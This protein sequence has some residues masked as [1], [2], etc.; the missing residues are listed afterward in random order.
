MNAGEFRDPIEVLELAATVGGAYA[1]KTRSRAWAKVEPQNGSN[2]FSRNGISARSV[3]LTIRENPALTAHNALRWDGKHLFISDIDRSSR[4]YYVLMCALIEPVT[5]TVKRTKTEIAGPLNRPQT[6]D[7]PPLVFPAC[8]TE[9]Y[10]GQ[11]QKEPM[12]Y[13]ETRFVLV[14]PKV[15]TIDAG[16]LVEISGEPYEVLIPRLLD[17]YKNEYEILRKADN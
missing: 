2:I 17:E 16:E 3:K 13:S 7:L 9:K 8:L 15:I 4:A 10:L 1:W 5:C 11:S 12:S 6:V 14:A